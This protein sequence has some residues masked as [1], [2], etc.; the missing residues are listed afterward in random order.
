MLEVQI[1]NDILKYQTKVIG[2]LS[3]REL[4]CLSAALV[5]D[6]GIF[7]LTRSLIPFDVLGFV[8]M[9]VAVPFLACGW[10]P[11]EIT[12]GLP[13]EKFCYVVFKT[14]FLMPRKRLYKIENEFQNMD[15]DDYGNIDAKILQLAEKQFDD[16]FP[17]VA[18]MLKEQKK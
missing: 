11:K 3:K 5:L 17:E 1:P 7:S 16:E 13:L 4:I 6:Y 8:L 9:G 15:Y 2:P 18:N 10:C 14:M 12:Y